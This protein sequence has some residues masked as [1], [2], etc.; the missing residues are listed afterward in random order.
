MD[1]V[2][3]VSGIVTRKKIVLMAL[4]S[5]DVHPT[6][7]AAS[8]LVMIMAAFLTAKDVMERL[9]AEMDLMKLSVLNV[10]W[11]NSSVATLLSAY[12]K[13]RYVIT[14]EIV[15]MGRMNH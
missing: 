15:Y 2:S 8:L 14:Q 3:K 4:M 12:P 11:M 5:K 9:I 7:P 13:A 10:H 1:I 6:V